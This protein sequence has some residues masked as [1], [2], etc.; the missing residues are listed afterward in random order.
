MNFDKES[1][2]VFFFFL[3]G[4]G[5]GGGG[6]GERAGRGIP[7]EKKNTH[8]KNNRYLLIFVLTLYKKFQVP[9][10]SGSLVST[11]T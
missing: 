7:T 6:G 4:G 11:Q 9:G 8:K 1:K 5:G 3:G 2:S 10:S